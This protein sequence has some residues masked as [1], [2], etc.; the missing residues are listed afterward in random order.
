MHY[1]LKINEIKTYYINLDKDIAQKESMEEVL[2]S[3]NFT[4]YERFPAIKA[5]WGCPKSHHAILSKDIEPPFIIL[6]DDCQVKN[7][8]L[9]M[10]IPDDV[11]AI[12]LGISAFGYYNG[13]ISTVA[14]NQV[15]EDV[16]RIYNM[17]S[18]H[19]IL[20]LSQRYVDV[21]KNISHHCGHLT[22]QPFDKSVAEIQKYYNVYALNNPF[23]YQDTYNKPHTYHDL[24]SYQTTQDVKKDPIPKIVRPEIIKFDINE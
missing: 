21:V 14:Y 9:E 13:N 11:D 7:E 24:R 18:G 22:M 15:T 20:Y 10:E 6:E 23:F 12:Y 19:A 16:S 8:V 2:T 17:L 5:E 3:S 1:M 4:N